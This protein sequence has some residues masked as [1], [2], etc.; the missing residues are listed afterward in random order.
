[1]P[2]RP[3]WQRQPMQGFI[4]TACFP[5]SSDWQQ[6]LG[7][8]KKLPLPYSYY[9]PSV[10]CTYFISKAA[11]VDDLFVET[12]SLCQFHIIKARLVLDHGVW[13]IIAAVALFSNDG[14]WMP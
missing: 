10:N 6:P 12:L 2:S 3:A 4:L 14:I 13:Q 8:H 7:Q 1:M 9:T 5:L 11:S